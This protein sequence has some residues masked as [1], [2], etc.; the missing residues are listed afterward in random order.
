L[1]TPQ[2]HHEVTCA[3]PYRLAR[4]PATCRARLQHSGPSA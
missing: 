3:A 1:A 4:A 2:Q